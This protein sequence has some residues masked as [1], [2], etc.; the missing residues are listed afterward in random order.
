M[1]VQK[2]VYK[3]RAKMNKKAVTK[4]EVKKLI[5]G[6]EETKFYYD[7]YSTGLYTTLLSDKDFGTY[8]ILQQLSTGTSAL[9][10]IGNQVFVQGV[11]MNWL[12]RT[13]GFANGKAWSLYG[14]LYIMELDYLT[15]YS[16][17]SLFQPPDTNVFVGTN[18]QVMT[19]PPA[20]RSADRV[21][22]HK[23]FN[24]KGNT[25]LGDEV[26]KISHYFK[27]NKKITFGPSS[28]YSNK[29]RDYYFVWRCA[30]GGVGGVSSQIGELCNTFR[31]SFK[32][33]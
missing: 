28:N 14:D 8:R 22:W 2:K 25:N 17:N 4:K 11:S 32:D 5:K 31:I 3:K 1:V 16:Y 26:L 12:L 33:S 9:N 20:I 18:Q 7:G 10:K 15:T 19:Y 23:S 21:L 30:S 6:S 24:I 29:L 27:I 13:F